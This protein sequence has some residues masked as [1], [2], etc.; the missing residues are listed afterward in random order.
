METARRKEKLVVETYQIVWTRAKYL[1][2][3]NNKINLWWLCMFGSSAFLCFHI[4]S[5]M[6][7]TAALYSKVNGA[8]NV[9][10]WHWKM[11]NLIKL[12]RMPNLSKFFWCTQIDDK[13]I[14]SLVTTDKVSDTSCWKSWLSEMTWSEE[15]FANC[16]QDQAQCFYVVR[17]LAT[18][19]ILSLMIHLPY[20][21]LCFCL[22]FE[23]FC[24][25]EPLHGDLGVLFHP[26]WLQQPVD[27][28]RSVAGLVVLENTHAAS[29]Y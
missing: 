2:L 9:V 14:C 26:V 21:R 25:I 15:C 20:T 28:A 5:L 4:E 29:E 8:S 12:K 11:K 13:N 3:Q 23:P 18:F 19:H 17:L 22:I 6:I 7:Y 27:K 16:C 10:F 24:K 1:C